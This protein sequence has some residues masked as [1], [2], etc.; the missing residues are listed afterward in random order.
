MDIGAAARFNAPQGVAADR[1]GNVYVADTGNFTIRRVVLAT[2]AVSLIAG[3]ARTSGW[4]DGIGTAARFYRPSAVAADDAG[5]VYVAD[6]KSYTIRKIVL[7]TGLVSTIAGVAGM[8]DES[9]S[10]LF[11]SPQGMAADGAG[12]LYITDLNGTLRKLVLATG[13]LTTVA[14]HLSVGGLGFVDGIGTNA[15]FSSPQGVSADGLGNLY[16]ADTGNNAI[17]KFVIATGA[18]FDDCQPRRLARQC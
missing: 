11:Y 8:R 2:G 7:A 9:S 5:N 6:T 10:A 12:N 1:A 17:R 14:G 15:L 13:E 18:V 16:I 4:S 3:A